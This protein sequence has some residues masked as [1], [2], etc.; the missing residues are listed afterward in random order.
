MIES[1]TVPVLTEVIRFTRARHAVLAGNVVNLDTP[2][3][4]VQDLSLETFQHELRA[5]MERS[6][7]PA[8]IADPREL[9][10]PGMLGLDPSLRSALRSGGEESAAKAIDPIR[11]VRRSE[12]YLL[13]HDDSNV[14]LEQQTA[15]ISKNQGLYNMAI[16]LLGS[17]FRLLQTAITERV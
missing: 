8:E 4:K 12:A 10:S 5:A 16:T 1:S 9:S 17:Q 6:L 14:T 2:G 13:R 15:A 3:Y 11:D 7:A